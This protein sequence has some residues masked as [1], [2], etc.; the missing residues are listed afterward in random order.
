[1]HVQTSIDNFAAADFSGSC[2]G[3]DGHRMRPRAHVDMDAAGLQQLMR[4]HALSYRELDRLGARSF[5]QPL[6]RWHFS[7]T[8]ALEHAIDLALA[9]SRSTDEE[10]SCRRTYVIT[11]NWTVPPHWRVDAR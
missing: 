6:F 10:S 2:M 7:T 3:T 4:D 8:A 1:L 9:E 5:A 11:R